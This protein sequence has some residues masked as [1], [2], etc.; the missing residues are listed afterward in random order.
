MHRS[1]SKALNSGQLFGTRSTCSM[2]TYSVGASA[3]SPLSRSLRHVAQVPQSLGQRDAIQR[4][5]HTTAAVVSRRPDRLMMTLRV[6]IIVGVVVMAWSGVALATRCR[7]DGAGSST[8]VDGPRFRTLAHA[9]S[10]NYKSVPQL[11]TL[12][13]NAAAEFVFTQEM[14]Q[15]LR[16]YSNAFLSR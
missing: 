7:S 13:P 11:L 10:I 8:T 2:D 12:F 6:R 15:R 4:P 3:Q 14:R 5:R 16:I 1:Y 9:T